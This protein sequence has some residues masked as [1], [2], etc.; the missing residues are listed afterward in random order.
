LAKTVEGRDGLAAHGHHALLVALADDIDE[1]RIQMQLLQPQISQF[2]QPEAGRVGELEDGL[3][4]QIPGR[5]GRFWLQQPRNLLVGQRLGQAF[6][7]ARQGQIFRDV[8]RQDFFVLGKFIKRAQRRDFQ[9]HTLAAQAFD[10]LPGLVGQRAGA[11]VLE[12]RHEMLEL[13]LLPVRELLRSGPGDKFAEQRGVSPGRVVRL[14]ALVPQELEKIFDEGLHNK[15]EPYPMA[16]WVQD[17]FQGA[18]M[19]SLRFSRFDREFHKAA[20]V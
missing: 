13:D 14:P 2:R 6:P 17:S 10:G 12:K 18:D 1:A 3:I 19:S 5:G 7:T 11:L 4:A 8:D 16:G 20:P 15:R 9:V